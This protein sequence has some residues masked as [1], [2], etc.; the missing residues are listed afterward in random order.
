MSKEIK[1]KPYKIQ[2]VE[3]FD[4]TNQSLGFLN[5]HESTDLRCQ[6]S[7]NKTEGYYLMFKDKKV[8]IRS[9]GHIDD[10]GRGLYDTNEI[11]LSRLFKLRNC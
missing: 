9:D 10:W 3:H 1:V 2:L 6:I 4:N 8:F 5:E 7:E 11:L